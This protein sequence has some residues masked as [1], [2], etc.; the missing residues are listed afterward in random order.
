[1]E[2]M[3]IEGREGTEVIEE[4]EVITITTGIINKEKEGNKDRVSTQT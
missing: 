2:S 3:E 4:I 1:M